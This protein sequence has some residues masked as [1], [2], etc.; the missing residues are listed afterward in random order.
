[1]IIAHSGDPTRF[2]DTRRYASYNGTAP[3]EASSGDVRRH[4]L[5]RG[6]NRQLNRALHVMAI[7][8]IRHAT[9]GRTYYQRKLDER[10]TDKEALRALKRQLSNVVYRRLFDDYQNGKSGSFPQ[11]L[12]AMKGR[13][14]RS[15]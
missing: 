14:L 15:C 11:Q 7:T 2:A 13:D 6:G 9:D 3:V 5:N 10:K 8:Q 12:D 4:R 1:M